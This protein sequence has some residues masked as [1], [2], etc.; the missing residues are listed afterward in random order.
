MPFI[1]E[2]YLTPITKQYLQVMYGQLW[3]DNITVNEMGV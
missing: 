1:T 3:F 2:A